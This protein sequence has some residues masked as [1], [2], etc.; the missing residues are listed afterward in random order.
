MK[1]T[2][3]PKNSDKKTFLFNS[4]SN[5]NS[6][7][8]VPLL[9][10]NWDNNRKSWMPYGIS[11]MMPYRLLELYNQSGFHSAIIKS[12]VNMICGGGIEQDIE[13]DDEYSEKTQNFIDKPNQYETMDELWKKVG[14]DYEIFGIA[15]L[16]VIFSN[17]RTYIAE[18]NHIDTTK[19][20]W[21]QKT[22]G[23]L[24]NFW[25]SEN[26]KNTAKYKPVNIPA[27]NPSIKQ[28]YPTQIL[29]IIKYSPDVQY[30]TLPTYY[31]SI[32]WIEID[33]QISNYHENNIKN[34]LMPTIFFGFP[35]GSPTDDEMEQIEKSLKSKL[36]GT[37]NA[38]S[39]ITAFYEQGNE[40]QVQV[41]D[42]TNASE[43]YQWLLEATQQQILIGAQVTDQQLV[44][45]ST[46]GK[47]GSINEIAQSSE[48]FY[49]QVIKHE[50]NDLL[51][52]F[53]KIM[54]YNGMNN[55]LISKDK[56][57][58][59]ELSENTLIQIL[60]KNELRDIVGYLPVENVSGQTE[61]SLSSCGCGCGQHHNH[62]E[63]DKIHLDL[64]DLKKGDKFNFEGKQYFFYDFID[65]STSMAD[66]NKLDEN[67]IYIW[68]NGKGTKEGPKKGENCP[69]CIQHSGKLR[70]LK[71]WK[72]VA[73]PAKSGVQ[74]KGSDFSVG[75]YGTYCEANCTC[76]LN[77]IKQDIPGDTF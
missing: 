19:V 71:Q 20:R 63:I 35:N 74:V 8:T 4:I 59:K 41:L 65:G 34:G 33:F 52:G 54:K 44:G 28:D 58:S 60:D 18:L 48:L 16:E 43:Q 27:F 62:S 21:G 55:I 36:G 5:I 17:D 2:E 51:A 69:A 3:V 46:A 75:K 77:L 47:L 24:T 72:Q 11:D 76:R 53:N 25:Y 7:D 42:I 15:Y 67:E 37:N 73:I 13:S 49:N 50:Q 64:S 22:K 26:F 61:L 68:T 40:V 32:K 12:K 39:F 38:G 9:N 10:T 6:H 66:I 56:L 29:P 45:I 14:F 31:S 1:I 30:Y 23:H 57:I 70:N